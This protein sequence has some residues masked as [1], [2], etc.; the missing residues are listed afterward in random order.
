MPLQTPHPSSQQKAEQTLQLVFQGGQKAQTEICRR[1]LPAEWHAQSGVQLTWPHEGTDWNYL[2]D[3]V[4]A[5]YLRLAYEIARRQPLLIVC[6]NT[7]DVKKLLD[8]QLPRQVMENIRFFSCETND[9]WARDHAFM[10]VLGEHGPELLDFQFNGWG[11]KFEAQLDNAINKKLFDADWLNGTYADHLDFVLEGGSIESDGK[12][13]LLTT[14]DCLLTPT[15][16]PQY[17]QAELTEKLCRY[18]SADNVLWLDHGYLSGDD[19]DSHI[20]TLARLCP[21]GV[22]VYVQCTDTQDEHYNALK[23]MEEQLKT[24]RQADGNAYTLY[25]LPMPTPIYADTTNGQLLTAEEAAQHSHAERLPATYA[26]FLILNE[27]I[28]YPTYGQPE[29]DEQAR[30]VLQRAFP[31]YDLVGIDCPV[32]S[33]QHGSLHCVTMQYPAGTLKKQNIQ[34]P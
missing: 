8:E 24:F 22:I 31:K 26:N 17:N 32:L 20:D 29:N 2:L 5:C 28:L 15:R 13:T 16:N 1:T 11:N 21:N 4:T 9:T 33:K 23:R 27:A 14:S 12:G 30:G 3:E 10:T 18:F 19:T 34:T 7:N 25:P 6:P